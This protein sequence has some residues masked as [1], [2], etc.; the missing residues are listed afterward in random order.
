M[1]I[2]LLKQIVKRQNVKKQKDKKMLILQK[3][4][5]KQMQKRSKM[6]A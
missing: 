4:R 1:Q 5:L 2:E 3:D 6:L